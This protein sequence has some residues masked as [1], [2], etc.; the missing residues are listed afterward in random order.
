[1][2]KPFLDNCDGIFLNYGWRAPDCGDPSPHRE[3]DRFM[4]DLGNRVFDMF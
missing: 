3:S 1:M 4:I 2:N